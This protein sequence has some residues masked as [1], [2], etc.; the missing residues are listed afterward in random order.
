MQECE[1]VPKLQRKVFSYAMK[2]LELEM[3]TVEVVRRSHGVHPYKEGIN[4]MSAF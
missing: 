3:L 4:F 1:V 2:R